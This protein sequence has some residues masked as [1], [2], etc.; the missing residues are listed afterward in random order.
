MA[1]LVLKTAIIRKQKQAFT[2][3]VQATSWIDIG[4]VD[5][6]SQSIARRMR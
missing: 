3:S 5:V 6:F 2:I 1:D 4:D